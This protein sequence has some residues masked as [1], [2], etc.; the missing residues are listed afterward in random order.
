MWRSIR[1]WLSRN[2]LVARLVSTL[3]F[4][5]F[6]YLGVNGVSDA[7]SILVNPSPTLLLLSISADEARLRAVI[8]AILNVGILAG[9]LAAMLGIWQRSRLRQGYLVVAALYGLMGLYQILTAV[10]Q[11]HR[12]ELAVAGLA[13]VALGAAAWSLGKQS[14]VSGQRSALSAQRSAGSRQR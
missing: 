3:L 11:F 12:P 6:V 10:F 4:A 2:R 7:A 13:Y 14:A 5:G 8:L 1:A 9:S